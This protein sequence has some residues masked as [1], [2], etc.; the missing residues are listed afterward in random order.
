MWY[1][2]FLQMFDEYAH[3]RMIRKAAILILKAEMCWMQMD[4]EG[5][6]VAFE[7]FENVRL[8]GNCRQS[9]S[10]GQLSAYEQCIP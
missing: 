5:G 7:L 10:L 4:N 3:F 1:S 6:W 8:L 2:L 9:V